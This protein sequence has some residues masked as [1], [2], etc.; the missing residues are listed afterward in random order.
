MGQDFSI[1]GAGQKVYNQTQQGGKKGGD[2][3]EGLAR[4]STGLVLDGDL[5][6]S[7]GSVG[8][9]IGKNHGR[10]LGFISGVAG[11]ARSYAQDL[12]E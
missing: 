7:V 6:D 1:R 3:G 4:A 8:R 12:L 10:Q 11:A 5:K 9:F 2:I